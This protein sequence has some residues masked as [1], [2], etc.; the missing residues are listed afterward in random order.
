MKLLFLVLFLLGGCSVSRFYHAADVSHELKKNSDQL[1]WM[2]AKVENDFQDKEA[3]FKNFHKESPNKES[4]I[5]G[6]LAYRLNDLKLKRDHI[7]SK[8]MFIKKVNDGLLQKMEKKSKI[9]ETDPVYKEIEDFAVIT[10]NDAKKLFEDFGK[11]KAASNEFATFAM[12]T[13]N[14]WKKSTSVIRK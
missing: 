4:Y 2:A 1:T 9:Q 7:L 5:V 3:F 6:D 14:L 10:Q 8:S 11:Y 12:F 13:G